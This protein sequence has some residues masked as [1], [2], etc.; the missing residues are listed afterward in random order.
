MTPPEPLVNFAHAAVLAW[1]GPYLRVVMVAVALIGAVLITR[2]WLQNSADPQALWDD[3]YQSFQSGNVDDARSKLVR[4]A[5]L[6]TPTPR[7]WTLTAQVAI[8]DN[9][10]DDAVAALSHVPVTDPI[11]G[12]AFLL[13]GRIDRQ[14]NRIRS[15]ERAFRTAIDCD[16]RLIEAH[17]ELIFIYGMQL[18]RQAVDG[19]FKALAR[20]APLSHHELFT[21]GI[22]HFTVWVRESAEQ[23]ESFIKADPEDRDSRLSLATLYLNSP[24]LVS[25]VEPTLAPLPN[26]DPEA[27]ALRVSVKLAQGLVDESAKLLENAPRG[28]PQLAAIR[29]RLAL[30]RG[31]PKEA[32]KDFQEALSGEPYDRSTLSD[33]GRALLIVGDRSA[34]QDFLAR[35]KRLDELF[36][37]LNGICR[38]ERENKP[39]DLVQ[40]AKACEAC[41]LLDEARGWYLLAIGREPLNPEA[42]QALRRL[43]ESTPRSG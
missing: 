10:P 11:A 26:N 31:S 5:L 38:P 29:G 3:A 22:T 32:I 21:W 42:Q 28:C 36:D 19:E 18:R 17:R 2:H 15:A 41:G 13:A 24:N 40:C 14:R 1:K 23:L 43:R 37:L 16:A 8:A 34:A 27:T 25:R 6:R 33:L 35:A 20:L 7:D 30:K 4:L 39:S 9:R 12:Q